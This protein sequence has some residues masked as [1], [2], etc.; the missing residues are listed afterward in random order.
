ME[1]SYDAD[2]NVLYLKLSDGRRLFVPKEELSELK[3]A[4]SEQASDIVIVLQGSSLW[5][6]QIDDGLHIQ[7]FL[8]KRWHKPREQ[9]SRKL[10]Q[11]A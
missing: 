5:W 7:D 2:K 4:T 1:T 3:N 11:A 10:P 9:P 8:E 6:P